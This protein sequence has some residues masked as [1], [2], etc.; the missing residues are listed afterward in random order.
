MKMVKT[1]HCLHAAF[2]LVTV[3]VGRC[4]ACI[5]LPL[6]KN[7]QAARQAFGVFRQGVNILA[8]HPKIGRPVEVMD[9]AYR[10]WPIAFGGN[11][12]IAL[13]HYDGKIAIIVTVRHQREAGF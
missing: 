4:S 2:D 13:Y 9:P 1:L 7:S 10:E 12:Y 3:C 8:L 5:S 6:G 11:G